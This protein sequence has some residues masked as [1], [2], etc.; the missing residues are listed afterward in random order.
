[1]PYPCQA[2]F[3][4]GAVLVDGETLL[5]LRV[6]DLQGVSHLT[7]ARSTDG[8]TDWRICNEPLIA[9]SQDA[10][11]YE[12]HG[13]EDSRVTY[14]ADLDKWV[15]A[16]TAYSPF[17]AGVALATTKDFVKVERF[18]L[19]LAPN[20]KDAAVFPRKING[21]YWMFHRPG[22]GSIQHIWLT[23]S[24]DLVHWGRPWCVLMERG[25]PMWDGF[26][27]GA[28]TVPIETS[29]GWLVIYHG[30]KMFAAGPTYRMGI[31]LLDLD[32][33]RKL[34]ARV[35]HWVLGPHEHYEVSG[36][37]AN[38][39]FACGH[40]QVGDDIRVYYGAADTCVCMASASITDLLSELNKHR[41]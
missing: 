28:N 1:M 8:M 17:G 4:P 16:Y 19:V 20:N 9:P 13:C 30:V 41:L 5:L 32:D 3:N 31:A 21:Q 34:I 27:V 36:A 39:V 33:P 15:I 14:L 40:T 12:E 7:V 35:P 10:G 22:A 29:E 26:K 23:E 24:T 18:G 38:V 37:V 6:E 2:V 11:P 25:G